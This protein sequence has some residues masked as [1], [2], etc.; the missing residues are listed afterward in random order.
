MIPAFT[1]L[2]KIESVAISPNGRLVLLSGSGYQLRDLHSGEL[3][4]DGSHPNLPRLPMVFLSD[5]HFGT[6]HHG[7]GLQVY[8]LQSDSVDFPD[9]YQYAVV[10][11]TLSELI[12]TNGIYRQGYVST[13]NEFKLKSRVR[14]PSEYRSMGS[15]TALLT[16]PLRVTCLTS[17]LN[18]GQGNSLHHLLSVPLEGDEKARLFPCGFSELEHFTGSPCGRYLVGIRGHAIIVW[19]GQNLRKAP[20]RWENNGRRKFTGLAFHPSGD[21]LLTA[22][23]DKGIKLW[24]M[25]TGQFVRDYHWLDEKMRS[26]AVAPDGLTA[27]A[28]C[29][30]GYFVHFDLEL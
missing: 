9:S 12:I 17:G 18:P 28:G 14:V 7:R 22:S 30:N 21:Y 6:Y 24:E 1:E 16:N 15:S 5:F 3:L 19:Q 29:D 11:P 25:A 10:F 20:Q 8:D 26:I 4:L 13:T 27:V 23:N 2:G